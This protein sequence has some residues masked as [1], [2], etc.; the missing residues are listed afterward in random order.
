MATTYTLTPTS[1]VVSGMLDGFKN[2]VVRVNWVYEATDGTYTVT[3]PHGFTILNPPS[4]EGPFIPFSSLTKDQV[5]QWVLSSWGPEQ[6]A[7]N[8]APLDKALADKAANTGM[9]VL[10]PPWGDDATKPW[11]KFWG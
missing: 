5:S 2:V 4:P 8:R 1:L 11:W 10:D 9:M 6:L 7:A 3:N